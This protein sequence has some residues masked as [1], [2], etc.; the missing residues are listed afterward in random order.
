MDPPGPMDS[1][2]TPRRMAPDRALRWCLVRTWLDVRRSVRRNRTL[3]LPNTLRLFS[4][5]WLCV[6]QEC[7]PTLNREGA[8]HLGREAMT[9]LCGQYLE[10][11]PLSH[12]AFDPSPSRKVSQALKAR[13]RGNSSTMMS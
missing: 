8:E 3:S 2:H 5:R 13:P 9:R 4:R 11:Q 1:R 12:D 6:V 7:E 10:A